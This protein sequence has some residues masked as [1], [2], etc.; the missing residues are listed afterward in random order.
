ME[1]RAAVP[2]D[3]PEI[4]RVYARARRYMEET[5]NPNQW[6]KTNPPAATLEDDIARG[7]LFVGMGEDGGIRLCFAL[8]PGIDPTYIEING[9]WRND[10][11]YAAI[12]RVASDGKQKG[13]FGHCVAF[14]R[15]RYANLRV[16]TH[17]DNKIM[18][19]LAEKHGFVRCGIIH[20]ADGSERIAYHLV[21]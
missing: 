17:R 2:G 15:E 14:A 9:A 16:D 19:H 11:P 18:Q 6:K 5:G 8:V 7:Q 20:I 3:M 21:V 10:E 12:H 13:V 1:I 4:L